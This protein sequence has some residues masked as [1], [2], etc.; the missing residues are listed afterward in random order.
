[1]HTCTHTHTKKKPEAK[2]K[3]NKAKGKANWTWKGAN[4]CTKGDNKVKAWNIYIYLAICLGFWISNQ[5]TANWSWWV[6]CKYYANDGA[7]DENDDDN[8][9]D[10]DNG[11]DGWRKDQL[12]SLLKK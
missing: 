1:M 6:E 4:N 2:A 5:T 8:D 7:D 9:N 3:W 12:A 11:N 10:D